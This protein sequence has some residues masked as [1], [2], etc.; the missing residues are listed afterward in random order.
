MIKSKQ[1]N[2]KTFIYSV[3]SFLI[4]LCSSSCLEKTMSFEIKNV[5]KK[6]NILLENNKKLKFVS[7]IE[8]VVKGYLDSDATIIQSD[9]ENDNYKYKL[10]KGQVEQKITG[11]WYS[12]K[13]LLKYDP[14]NAKKGKLIITYE[15][16]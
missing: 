14:L 7:G 15:F 9:G 16:Y 5:S 4:V 12:D 11:D 1:I 3:L 6:Q 10:A 8:I 13:C 2:Y